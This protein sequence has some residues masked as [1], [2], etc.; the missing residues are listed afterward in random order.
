VLLFVLG[1]QVTSQ[2][3]TP[4]DHI[5]TL[6]Q[7]V[8]G[9]WEVRGL[10]LYTCC[11]KLHDRPLASCHTR[12]HTV[13]HRPLASCQTHACETRHCHGLPAAKLL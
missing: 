10:K 11:V 6:K 4:S 5:F 8:A 9:V 3:C 7:R 12:C 1:S 13:R 2:D